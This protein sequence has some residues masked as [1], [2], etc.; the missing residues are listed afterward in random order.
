MDRD[1]LHEL[2]LTLKEEIAA[3]RLKINSASSI[4]SLSNV[5]C[6]PDGNVDPTTVDSTVRALGLAAVAA[7]SRREAKKISLIDTQAAYFE[8]VN[9]LI[10]GPFSQMRQRG[11][12]PPQVAESLISNPK[13]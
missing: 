4:N 5:R 6:G 12:T 13:M 2:V 1:E 11:L 3:G 10:G 9:K 8:M 7:R